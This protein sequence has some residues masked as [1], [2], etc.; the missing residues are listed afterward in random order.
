MHEIE[1][2][3]IPDLNA[4][5]DATIHAMKDMDASMMDS[6]VHHKNTLPP[7]E[8]DGFVHLDLSASASDRSIEKTIR[9]RPIEVKTGSSPMIRRGSMSCAHLPLEVDR[10]RKTFSLMTMVPD[11]HST[12][13]DE[14]EEEEEQQTGANDASAS[15]HK[16]KDVC[17]DQT[18]YNGQRTVRPTEDLTNSA[19]HRHRQSRRAIQGG[20]LKSSLRSSHV[21]MAYDQSEGGAFQPSMNMK[22]NV[23]F[24]NLEIHSYGI[25]V[26]D[27][28]S[29]NDPLISL[30][31]S[32]HQS[33]EVYDIED[34]EQLRSITPENPTPSNP[35]LINDE[36]FI[37]PSRRDYLLM[38]D[39]GFSRMQIKM[40]TEEAQCAAKERQK[41]AKRSVRLDE[42]L[43]K[44]SSRF[45]VWQ[46][47][48]G[49][50]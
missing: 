10:R 3:Q 41:G 35:R 15:A 30:D 23:S 48:S 28:P 7:E 12:T 8:D 34:Y 21:S 50:L 45:R 17:L 11:I 42:M 47:K 4:Y 37:Q 32:N 9:P 20:P 40:A 18:L 38:R 5:A 27:G 1:M 14:E 16:H 46:K 39:A 33:K 36:L 25:A 6:C 43:E 13:I 29:L 2:Y 26:A 31:F 19:N 22:Q 24:S 44:A 49:R